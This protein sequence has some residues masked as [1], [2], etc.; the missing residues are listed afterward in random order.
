MFSPDNDGLDDF[1]NIEINI[2]EPDAAASITIYDSRG[3]LVVVLA[4][5]ILLSS[6]EIF[7]WNGLTSNH[8]RAPMG[9]YII[10]IELTKPNGT[11][12]RKKA[13]AFLCGK[14]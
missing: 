9:S 11:V 1:L 10:F 6:Q 5:N 14:L 7:S 8:D 12:V 4:N 2:K 13:T 3:R